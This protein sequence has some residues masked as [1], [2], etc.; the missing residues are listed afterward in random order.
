MITYLFRS[1]RVLKIMF[2]FSFS[3][4][5][6]QITSTGLNGKSPEEGYFHEAAREN[7][8]KRNSLGLGA[9]ASRVISENGLAPVWH[10]HYSR[11]FTHTSP[12]AVTMGYERLMHKDHQHSTIGIGIEYNAWRELHIAAAPGISF[13]PDEDPEPGLH[14]EMAYEFQWG[15]IGLG[16]TVE[17]GLG[18]DDSH[19]TLGIHTGFDF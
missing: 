8:I 14:F 16:P 3:F 10:L 9:G 17:Y 5:A 11:S 6:Q 7:E 15:K 2:L 18:P 13:I 4:T 19:F 1:T 12:F